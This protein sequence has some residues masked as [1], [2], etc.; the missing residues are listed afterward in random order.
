MTL[1]EVLLRFSDGSKIKHL[2]R[3]RD[4]SDLMA[5]IARAYP[6]R[7]LEVLTLRQHQK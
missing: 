7:E 4:E 1:F 2:S 5:K 6:K 3:Q